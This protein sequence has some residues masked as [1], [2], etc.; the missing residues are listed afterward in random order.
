MSN[1]RTFIAKQKKDINGTNV[2]SLKSRKR[3]EGKVNFMLGIEKTDCHK[4]QI[5]ILDLTLFCHTGLKIK[6]GQSPTILYII[7][8]AYL[9][10]IYSILNRKVILIKNQGNCQLLE[11]NG[12]KDT[13]S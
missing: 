1:K 11:N 3:T 6:T 7:M 2:L 8:Y 13:Y 4:K 10:L 9:F 12:K 5:R